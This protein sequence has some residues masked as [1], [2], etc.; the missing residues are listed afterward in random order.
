L[1]IL[2]YSFDFHPCQ[3]GVN[4]FVYGL[5]K[6]LREKGHEV[7]F[8]NSSHINFLPSDVLYRIQNYQNAFLR[9]SPDVPPAIRNIEHLR[10]ANEQLINN[11]NIKKYDVIHSNNGVTSQIIQSLDPS[12]PLIGTI[13]GNYYKESLANNWVNSTSEAEWMRTY[14]RY[15]V[16]CPT[17]VHTVSKAMVEDLPYFPVEKHIV[18]PNGVKDNKYINSGIKKANK[19]VQIAGA[20]ILADSKG[21][22]LLLEAVEKLFS[23][24]QKNFHLTLYGDGPARINL[25]NQV[26]QKN[27]PVTFQ[28]FVPHQQL[29]DELPKYD[30]FAHPSY[31]ETFGLAV[32]EAMAAGCAV[33]C[34]DIGGLKEQIKHQNN[35]LLFNINDAT[36][37][38]ECLLTLMKDE[39]L[40]RKLQKRGV[41]TAKQYSQESILL[42]FEELYERTI[43]LNLRK[44]GE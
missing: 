11:I 34:T 40:R 10:F 22:G 12:I 6:G 41:E 37:L 27:L 44:R 30:I 20:G 18:I 42:R 21:Y 26:K 31:Y 5:L 19:T 35:G 14:D 33:I 28:G 13:H 29:L 16:E 43:D 9:N 23:K 36:N 17:F 4:T 39:P 25:E 2:L 7:D 3:G 15:A 1:K 8:L 32:T 38:A 24:G